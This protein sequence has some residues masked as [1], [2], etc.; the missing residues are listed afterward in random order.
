MPNIELI[1][2]DC[3][4]V[5]GKYPDKYFDLAIC[6]PPYGIGVESWD[7]TKPNRPQFSEA[8]RNGYSK[9]ETKG[10]DEKVPTAEYWQQLFR[11]SVQQIIWGGNYF[12][13]HL[14]AS[15]GWIFW[16]K[17]FDK[18]NNFSHGEL[19][20]SSFKIGLKK[21]TQSSK[22]ETKGGKERIHPTQKPVKLYKWLLKN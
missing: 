6:D 22:D 17:L 11:I 14:F 4:N 18:T 10:W 8:V 3:M 16:D 15:R 5:M 9:Y 20:W 12:T 19:A 1:N 13:E 2:D 21:F 7:F